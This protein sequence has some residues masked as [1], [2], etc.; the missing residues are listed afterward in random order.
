MVD[1]FLDHLFNQYQKNPSEFAFNPELHKYVGQNYA[2][3]GKGFN[4]QK[5]LELLR[6]IAFE[7]EK[8]SNTPQYL[9]FLK[10][11]LFSLLEEP[12]ISHQHTISR[13]KTPSLYAKLNQMESLYSPYSPLKADGIPYLFKD[14]QRDLSISNSQL[15]ALT[16][17]LDSYPNLIPKQNLEHSYNKTYKRKRTSSPRP[18]HSPS[19]KK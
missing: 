3:S 14:P 4:Q 18:S 12:G 8:K 7:I 10:A 19:K 11:L 6:L 2:P 17:A 1:Q 15:H 13:K 5:H 16:T 9:D